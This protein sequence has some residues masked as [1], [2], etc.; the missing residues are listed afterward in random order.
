M[1]TNGVSVVIPT[2]R[3]GSRA[4][5]SLESIALSLDLF[6][7]NK[8]LIIA[9]DRNFMVN[10]FLLDFASNYNFVK[11]LKI[12]GG[13]GSAFTRFQA[14]S[15]A[16][17]SVVIFTDDDCLVP[18]D[19]I[20]KMFAEVTKYGMV[21]GNLAAFN[22]RN[23]YSLVDAYVDQLRIKSVDADG[24]AKYI[25]FPNFGI[26]Q[27]Y[28]PSLPFL[29]TA[30]NT[31]ED[32]DLACRLRLAGRKIY[33]AESLLIITEYPETFSGLLKRKVKHAQGIAFLRAGLE[34]EKL[35]Y[36][37]LAETPWRMLR[38][39][40]VLSFKAPLKLIPR[41]IMFLANLAYCVAL[42]YYDN[43]FG[44]NFANKKKS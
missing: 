27:T 18:L 38:R 35:R 2:A 42:A 29:A 25:S 10:D 13:H 8:E 28:L 33:F 43:K 34:N 7:G 37:G 11:L 44:K 17:Y 4:L 5:K 15:K 26:K 39:W 3:I 21:A 36:L 6:S 12:G 40:S 19:W 24:Y 14:L 23:V 20:N 30:L 41:I 32:I 1:E 31:T 9:V 16:Q 22:E